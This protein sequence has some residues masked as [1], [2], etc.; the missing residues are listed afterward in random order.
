MGEIN[1]RQVEGRENVY[2]DLAHS[3][4]PKK[5]NP[6]TNTSIVMGFRN[7]NLIRFINIY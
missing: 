3:A 6:A 1:Y 7:A 2:F 5:H 4:D